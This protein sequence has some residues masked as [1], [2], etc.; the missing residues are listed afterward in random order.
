MA[1][2]KMV[3]PVCASSPPSPRNATLAIKQAL[4]AG[5]SSPVK[6][7]HVGFSRAER[8]RR[9]RERPRLSSYCSIGAYLPSFQ[10]LMS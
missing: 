8:R 10:T 1:E 2:S 7:T 3:M 4:K 5:E 6:A 9:A